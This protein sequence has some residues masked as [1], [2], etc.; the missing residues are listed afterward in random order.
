M[1]GAP[2]RPNPAAPVSGPALYVEQCQDCHATPVGARYAQSLHSAEG[3][4]CGQCHTPN[5]HP[6]FAQPVQDGKCGGCH[7]S[8][9]QQTLASKHFA[10]RELRALDADRAARQALRADAFT[11]P[12]AGGGRR[13]VGDS[14]S[15]ELGGRLCTACH[16]DEHRL[17]LGP[18]QRADF[19]TGCHV[20]R[21]EHFPGPT[22]G[23]ANRCVQCHVRVGHTAR[24]Q[25]VNTHLFARPG[26]TP[27][28]R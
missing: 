25:V 8:Q 11:A 17:G 28:G 4:R 5:G 13:F 27:A 9:Y 12:T 2:P 10:T 22:P 3:I 23:L 14:S 21:E 16:Y 6:D 24:G 20:G 19:C 26:A 15:G 7:Q 1:S 18:V